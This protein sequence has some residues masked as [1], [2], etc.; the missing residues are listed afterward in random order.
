MQT[1]LPRQGSCISQGSRFWGRV[2]GSWVER[3]ADPRRW[4][5]LLRLDLQRAVRTSDLN[6]TLTARFG[7]GVRF[8][9]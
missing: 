7:S 4:P 9:F 3:L 5:R 1:P 6:A 8:W 2:R